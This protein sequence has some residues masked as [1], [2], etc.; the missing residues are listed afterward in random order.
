MSFLFFGIICL[1]VMNPS[2]RDG[3]T[4]TSCN[5]FLK[6]DQPPAPPTPPERP[7]F[8]NKLL[9]GRI[10]SAEFF[11]DCAVV[12]L[13]VKDKNHVLFVNNK[14]EI[15]S[16]FP[17]TEHTPE[18]LVKWIQENPECG[19]SFGIESGVVTGVIVT[20]LE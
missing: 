2:C 16:L 4:I 6:L 1:V 18:S 11:E 12:K 9:A 20:P 8:P 17:R 5:H 3:S 19:G 13:C 15:T 14:A 10:I 7:P